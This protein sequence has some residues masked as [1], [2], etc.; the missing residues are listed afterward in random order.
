MR[1]LLDTNIIL[2]Y[3]RENERTRAIERDYGIFA[4]ENDLF[5]SVAV[6]AE[7]RSFALRKQYGTR[8]LKAIQKIFERVRIIG[9][10]FEEILDRYATI[11]AYSQGELPNVESPFTARNMG[12]NDLYIAATASVFDLSLVT[13]DRDFSHIHQTHLDLIYVDQAHYRNAS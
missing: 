1:L 7:V 13:T 3:G 6:L 5:T 8:K 10:H 4:K 2:I 12:K 9:V 11:D